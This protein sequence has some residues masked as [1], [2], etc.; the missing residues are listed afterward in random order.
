[1][2]LRYAVKPIEFQ[3]LHWDESHHETTTF[4]NAGGLLY[5]GYYIRHS[6]GK[7]PNVSFNIRKFQ[8]WN[9]NDCHF[10]GYMLIQTVKTGTMK[11]NSQQGPFCTN[12]SPSQPFVGKI[13]PKYIVLGSFEYFLIIY[14]FGPLYNID[15]DIEIHPSN[16]EGLF[17]PQYMCYSALTKEDSTVDE[18]PRLQRY[19]QGEHYGMLCVVMRRSDV[20]LYMLETYYI[21]KCLILQSISFGKGHKEYYTF[22]GFMDIKLSVTKIPPYL[23]DGKITGSLSAYAR[24]RALD[25]HTYVLPIDRPNTNL[26]TSYPEIAAVKLRILN[27]HQS[28]SMYVHLR[29][30]TIEATNNCIHSI[31]KRHIFWVTNY[32]NTTLG[33]FEISNLCGL[34]RYTISFIY[35]FKFNFQLGVQYNQHNIFLYIR[36]YSRC[37]AMA[38]SNVLTIVAQRATVSHSVILAEE[39][40]ALDQLYEPIGVVYGNNF[41]C[42][43]QMVY[44]A[45][46]YSISTHIGLHYKSQQSY[47]KVSIIA[48]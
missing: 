5:K 14:A 48:M 24:L 31:D 11:T 35:L 39:Q 26:Q 13:G 23:P 28:Q 42:E 34:L 18:T 16:C 4:S 10:G 6:D 3:G 9:G 22:E 21:E 43:F 30:D 17:E 7:F 12:S 32:G 33:V 1:M 29:V 47:I 38:V 15:V 45:R 25:L 20:I 44:R 19:I 8:G 27:V 36:L 37:L 41:G 2:R 46:L 40:Y